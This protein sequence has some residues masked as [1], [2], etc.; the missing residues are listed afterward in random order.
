MMK[1]LGGLGITPEQLG[2]EKI[3]MLMKLS[4]DI[5]NPEKMKTSESMDILSKLGLSLETRKVPKEV[6]QQQLRDKKNERS[7]N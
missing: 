1:L 6:L 2:P 3:E 5:S 7:K 4:E